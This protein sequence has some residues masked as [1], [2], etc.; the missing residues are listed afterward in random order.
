MGTF[1]TSVGALNSTTI[2]LGLWDL[3]IY[4]STSDKAKPPSFYSKIYQ[5]DADGSGN[6]ILLVDGSN[7]PIEITS[8]NNNEVVL[9]NESIYMPTKTLTDLTTSF[10][11]T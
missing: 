11:F 8:L 10:V 5:V 2:P 6:P 3:N 1:T 7:V 4:A 9:Y